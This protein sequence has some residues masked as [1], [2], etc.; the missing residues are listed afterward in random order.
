MAIIRESPLGII[1]GKIGQI[2]GA[3][4]KGINYVRVIPG[5]VAQPNTDKQL[6]QRAKFTTAY[7]FVQPIIQFLR[8]GYKNY[9]VRMSAYNAAMREILKNAV[10]GAYPTFAIDY[11]NALVSKGTLPGARN[12][13]AASTVAGTVLFTWVDN[14]EETGASNTDTT[15]IVVYNATKNWA[16]TINNL[17]VR[18]EGTQ[19][20]TVPSAFSG[21]L[22]HCYISFKTVDGE[23]LCDSRYAGAVTVA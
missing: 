9:A 21:D 22:V 1:S 13:V 14:T 15:L 11:P 5:S 3:K 10:T 4:W 19:A 16:V 12:A 20:V 18:A 23:L 17:A 8:T 2:S 7:R 6:A